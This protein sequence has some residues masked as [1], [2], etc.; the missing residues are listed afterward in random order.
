MRSSPVSQGTV[1]TAVALA[2][3]LSAAGSSVASAQGAAEVDLGLEEIVVTARKVEENLMT[4][5]LAIT[6]FSAQAIENQG[7]KQ[8]TDVMRVTPSFNFV[9]QQGGSGRNDRSANA[10]V[11]RGLY[12]ANNVGVSA[13]GQLFIDGA[14][15][16]GAQ[17]P[18]IADVARI[19]ILQGPQSAYFGRSTFSGALNFIMKEPGE[20]FGGKVSL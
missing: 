8:L 3:A 7:I 4:V 1:A 5:P 9:N 11:F 17:P 16:L 20:E 13:G 10:L 15:V 14:P 18:P 6:A 19:E 12:L 2:I